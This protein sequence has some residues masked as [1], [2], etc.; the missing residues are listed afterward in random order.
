MKKQLLI[1]SVIAL[2]GCMK[3][4]GPDESTVMPGEALKLPPEYS[5]TAPKEVTTIKTD[6]EP[7]NS[8]SQKILLNG[9]IEHDDKNV[10]NWIIKNAGG[11]KRVKNIKEILK[12]D[13]KAEQ[14]DD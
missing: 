13:L 5:L 7:V 14:Q 12:E 9:T 4:S 8:R 6:A 3:K 1:L 11:N 2:A 10:N